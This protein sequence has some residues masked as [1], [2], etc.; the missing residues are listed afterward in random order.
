MGSVAYNGAAMGTGDHKKSY[1]V[2]GGAGFVG[3]H[4]VDDLLRRDDVARVTVFDNL[5]SG[6]KAFLPD[7]GRVELIVGD[8][9][10]TPSLLGA[11]AGHD[12]IAHFASNPDISKAAVEPDLDFRQG[13]CLTRNVVEAARLSG[14]RS[15]VYVSGSGVYGDAGER[16][17]SEDS[18]PLLPVSPYGAS[19][20]AGEAIV[21]AYARMFDFKACVFR[22]ANI[23]G[24]RQSHGVARDFVRK[25]RA[26]PSR[27]DVLGDGKQNKSY[28]HVLDAVSAIRI[29]EERATEP[30]AVFNV[31]S[32][33][34]LTVAEI[35]SLSATSLGLDPN[36]VEVRYRG[37]RSGWK[38]DVPVVRLSTARIRSLGWAPRFSSREAVQDALLW[39]SQERAT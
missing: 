24:P 11:A 21:S 9:A 15:V 2:V 4:F 27:L 17:L 34:W 35:A 22:F 7:N 6:R 38:G 13:T 14:A 28:L 33:D 23:V 25:L 19:K 18:G 32:E 39:L 31:A 37:G 30:V 20:L 1:L 3:S 8:A 10:D 16:I 5:S 26:E 12:V 36:E 29:A